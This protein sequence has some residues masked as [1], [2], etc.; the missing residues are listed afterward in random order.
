VAEV[1]DW[2]GHSDEALDAMLASLARLKEQGLDVI[3][4]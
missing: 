1:H 3:E 2:P 4:D